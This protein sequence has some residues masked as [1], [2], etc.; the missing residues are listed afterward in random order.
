[1]MRFEATEFCMYKHNLWYQQF[2]RAVEKRQET[3]TE[4]QIKKFQLPLLLRLAQ[5][6]AEFSEKCE[7]C[8]G[9]QQILTRLEEE[10]GELPTSQAQRQYQKRQIQAQAAHFRQAHGLYTPGY[11]AVTGLTLGLSLGSAVGILLGLIVLQNPAF[12]GLGIG[13]GLAVGYGVGSSRD[14]QVK[15]RQV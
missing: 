8:R 5:R 14:A 11:F 12:L 2:T 1:M 4:Q 10:M 13:G 15:Q 9:Y 6:V 3:F 7:T